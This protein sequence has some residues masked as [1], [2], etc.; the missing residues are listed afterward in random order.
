M[1]VTVKIFG[2]LRI[3]SGKKELTVE[4]PGP[5]AVL[6]DILEKVAGLKGLE[7]LEELVRNGFKKGAPFIILIDGRNCLDLQGL[8]TEVRDGQTVSIFPPSAGG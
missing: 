8:G 7:E 6:R 1:V 5:S 2:P 4:L 3:S